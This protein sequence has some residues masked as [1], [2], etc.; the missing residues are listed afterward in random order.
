MLLVSLKTTLSITPEWIHEMDQIDLGWKEDI[1]K[2]LGIRVILED[3]KQAHK[4]RIQAAHYVWR[5]FP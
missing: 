2:Y 1:M 3:G 4:F 5:A